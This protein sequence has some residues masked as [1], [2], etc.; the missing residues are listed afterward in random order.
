MRSEEEI[1]RQ[2]K[3]FHDEWKRYVKLPHFELHN[4]YHLESIEREIKALEW[5]LGYHVEWPD[6]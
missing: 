5:V 4:L 6:D 1:V 3:L 2:I